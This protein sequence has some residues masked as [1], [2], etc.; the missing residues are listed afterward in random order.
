VKLIIAGSRAGA[1]E[2]NQRRRL[3]EEIVSP[4]GVIEIVTGGASGVDTHAA[5]F[6]EECSLDLTFF[7]ANWKK[8]GKRA[9]PLRI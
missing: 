7:M 3:W 1:I 9:G 5:E 8:H 6:A 4:N 2:I